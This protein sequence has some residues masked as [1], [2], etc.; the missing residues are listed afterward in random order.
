MTRRA[1]I[2]G[3]LAGQVD[4]MSTLHDAGWEVHACG[5]E[6][7]GPGVEAADAFHLVD[8]LDVDAVAALCVEHEIDVLY[9]VGSDIAMP[10]VA[11]VSERLGL[12]GF[13]DVPTTE[14]LHRK[15]LLRAFLDEHGI[16]PVW[17]CRVTDPG[18][19][20]SPPSMPVIVKPSDS[21]GQR[22]ITIVDDRAELPGAIAVAVE[23]SRSSVAIVEELLDGPE[24]SVHVVVVDGEVRF[25]LPSDRHVWDGPLV[26]IPQA[27]VMPS[28]FLDDTSRGQVRAL[29]DEVVAA[30]GVTNGPLYFQLILTGSGPRIIE[31]AP[32]LD[33]CHLWRLVRHHV[34][35]DL[36]EAVLRLLS[37]GEWTDVEVDPDAPSHTLGFFL[38]SPLE[39]FHEASF[40]PPDGGR[41]VHLEYQVP[42]GELPRATNDVVARLGYWV[43][44]DE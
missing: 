24:V 1:L 35:F 22:G 41:I 16:S 10:T 30:L 6:R 7:I 33:G 40:P 19:D 15:P 2:L 27:H 31:I 13:H 43:R 28:R 36:M 32:R 14:V 4:A 8:I 11:A 25:L 44:E 37:D 23:S 21:Q 38:G 34:G 17:S 9:S 42:E 5:H 39:P 18:D 3:T 29:V 26:G 20:V 12:P